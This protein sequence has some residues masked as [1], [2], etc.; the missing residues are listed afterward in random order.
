MLQKWH[1]IIITGQTENK[2]STARR[3]TGFP[4]EKVEN[5]DLHKPVFNKIMTTQE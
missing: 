1:Q 5:E 4:K 3:R 2:K